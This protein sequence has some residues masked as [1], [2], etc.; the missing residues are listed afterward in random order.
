[1]VDEIPVRVPLKALGSGLIRVQTTSEFLEDV[2]SLRERVDEEA[3]E[4]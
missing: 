3:A 2:R 4:E 1:M